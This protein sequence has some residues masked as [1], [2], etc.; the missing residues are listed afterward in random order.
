[1]SGAVPAARPRAVHFPAPERDPYLVRL[2][3][4]LGERGALHPTPRRLTLRWLLA[5]RAEAR[6]LHFHWPSTFYEAWRGGVVRPGL[7]RLLCLGWFV[8]K[9][10]AAK[11]L[12]YRLVW[13]AH[14]VLPHGPFRAL[15][16]LERRITCGRLW[17]GVIA[18]CPRAAE[19]VRAQLGFRGPVAILPH[20]S[21][22]GY[23]PD[24]T[25]RDR[26]REA[27][28]VG[29]G[30]FLYLHFGAI[31]PY[32]GIEALIE[33][34]RAS[35]PEGALLLVAGGGDPA[36]LRGLRAACGADPRFRWVPRRVPDGE[37]AGL[38]H[39]A[40]AVV[41]PYRRVTTSGTLVLA[42][43]FGKRVV[44]PA[45]GC[46]PDMVAPEF[47]VTYDPEGGTSAL[48]EAL[49]AVRGLDP[50][51]AAEAARARVGAWDWKR[52]ADR[53]A[54]FYGAL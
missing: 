39:A 7:L 40:D 51:R 29:P 1:M 18:H 21:L 22:A 3:E 20:G 28:G 36:Y 44:I 24:T 12:G 47:A 23:Y 17:D 15:Y 38:M 19:A 31:R 6:V 54:E 42:M 9:L 52:I 41:L 32:K 14:D 13:T 4:A 49:R 48:A 5:A 16:R 34:F 46:V 10:A 43:G 53:T 30:E 27:L 26:S 45:T 33:A 25:D 2:C 50:E 8:A 35:P 11:S 37:V